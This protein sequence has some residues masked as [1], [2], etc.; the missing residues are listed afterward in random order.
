ML[1]RQPAK[2][3]LATLIPSAL[4]LLSALAATGCGSSSPAQAKLIPSMSF[5][6]PAIPKPALPAL[7]TC[8]GK[9][10]S[11]PFVWGAVPAEAKDLALFVVGFTP[12]A[13]TKTY[14]VSVEWAAAGVNPNLHRMAAGQLPSGAFLGRNSDKHERY[15]ICPKKGT[16]I[17]YQFEAYGVPPGV[18]IPPHFS[19]LATLNVL[20]SAQSKGRAVAH[21]GFA[22]QYK[23]P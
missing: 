21:G 18:V 16:N 12:Q 19:S 20:V 15:S 2:A 7:Y 1:V 5:R 6:S 10:I 3:I 13:A 9:N 4:I 14:S 17:H 11:P 22:A 8:D 23:R